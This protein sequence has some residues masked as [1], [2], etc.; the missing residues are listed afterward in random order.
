M[1]L[2]VPTIALD[3]ILT[4]LLNV[5]NLKLKL[6]SNNITVNPDVVNADF[7]EVSGGGYVAVDLDFGNWDIVDGVATYNATITF[8]FDDV[9][10]SPGTIY[11]YWIVNEDDVT[12]I[13]AENLPSLVLPFTP[14][15]GSTGKVTPV[16]AAGS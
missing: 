12:K 9:T 4:D 14:I 15:A 5:P 10:D 6:F 7:T 2:V 8:T 1:T 13:W 16:I 11:G 3:S